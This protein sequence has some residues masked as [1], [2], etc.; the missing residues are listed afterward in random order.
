MA[1][2]VN[3]VSLSLRLDTCRPT[4]PYQAGTPRRLATRVPAPHRTLSLSPAGG[5]KRRPR[6]RC[7]GGGCSEGTAFR[8]RAAPLALLAGTAQSRLWLGVRCRERAERSV[9]HPRASS[10]PRGDRRAWRRRPR[11]SLARVLFDSCRYAE[12]KT[13]CQEQI[14]IAQ[15][16]L[17]GEHPNTLRL[18]HVYAMCLQYCH[19]AAVENDDVAP[20]DSLLEDHVEATRILEELT[21]IARRVFGPH[22]HST[23]LFERELLRARRRVNHHSGEADWNLDPGA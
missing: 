13:F 6:T 22:H 14:P 16:A 7:G 3:Y 2:R 19:K 12:A 8:G 23:A 9:P 15:G 1:L 5:V 4:R 11:K 21:P 17:G 20:S 18:K 10:R